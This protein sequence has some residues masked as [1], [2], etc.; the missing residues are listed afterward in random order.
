MAAKLVNARSKTEF[1][2]REGTNTVGR[3]GDNDVTL[4]G[5]AV[6]RFHAEIRLE[7]EGWVIEDQGSS[8]GTFVNGERVR[9]SAALKNGDALRF[10][11][12]EHAPEGEFN[13]VFQDEGVGG[14]GARLKRAV[15]AI[16]PR[17]KTETGD[18]SLERTKEALVVRISG[19]LRKREM[20]AIAAGVKRELG[21]ESYPVVVDLTEV[22]HLNSYGLAVLVDLA[23]RQK[24]RGSLLCVFGA[25][26]TVQKVL[27]VPGDAAPFVR[28]AD[29][30]EA[31][32]AC[33]PSRGA[34]EGEGD[35]EEE[36]G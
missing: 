25:S 30:D 32:E 31:F 23:A 5:R 24:E 27:R 29:E 8:Y 3:H 4:P 16:A 18:M 22:T 11:V 2:L 13:L 9:G 26:G 7:R 28:C 35:T 14:L 12:T 36:K 19:L 6:S 33:A 17:K 34:G 20:D 21:A 1:P 15:R 10:A